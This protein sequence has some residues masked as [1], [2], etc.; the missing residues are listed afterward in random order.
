MTEHGVAYPADP[1]TF[2]TIN[3]TYANAVTLLSDG[4]ADAAFMGGAT[5]TPAVT[6]ACVTEDIYF[7]PYEESVRLK[8]IDSYPFYRDLTIP[9]ENAQ[10]EPTYSDLTEDFPSLDV[11]SMHL[12]APAEMDDDLA[13]QVTKVIWE[14][15]DAIAEQHPAGRAINEGNAA[16]FT[17]TPFHPGSAKFYREI[18]IWPEENDAKESALL[19]GGSP[20]TAAEQDAAAEDVEQ[21][22]PAAEAAEAGGADQPADS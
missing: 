17:G 9:A 21:G 22:S 6:Q 10:G 5:P 12:I 13:Y 3:D 11:G 15:R 7:I 16:R 14:N 4:Q 1:P 2:T 8:L 19:G 18:G 20:E